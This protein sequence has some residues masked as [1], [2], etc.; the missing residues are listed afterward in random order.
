MTY[1]TI[2]DILLNFLFPRRCV[3]CG[4]FGNYFCKNCVPRLKTIQTTICPVC[5]K[6]SPFGYTHPRCQTRYSLDGLTSV[7]RYKGSIQ[8]A[9][10]MIKYRRVTDLVPELSALVTSQIKISSPQAFMNFLKAKPVIIPIPLHWWRQRGRSFNQSEL[11]AQEV[12]K[13]WRL[14]VNSNLLMRKKL[15]QSQAGLKKDERRLNI[16]SA[17]QINPKNNQQSTINNVVLLDDVWT[18]GSTM[19]EAG[20]V[21]KR[22]GVTNV[23]ALTIAQ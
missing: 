19:R 11:I 10:K 18:T 9:I 20:N 15:T 16:K 5:T 22:A 13:E 17:F 6:L 2:S 8:K 3:S 21:L 4:T 14:T 7:F 23:W 12:A 1:A